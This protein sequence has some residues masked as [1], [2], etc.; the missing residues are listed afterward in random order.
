VIWHLECVEPVESGSVTAV[1][2]EVLRYRLDLVG[3]LV[4]RWDM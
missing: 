4:V 2:R 3:V 1:A